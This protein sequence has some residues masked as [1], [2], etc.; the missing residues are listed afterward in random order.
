MW[1][2]DS[3]EAQRSG[4]GGKRRSNGA[5][6]LWPFWAEGSDTKP[7]PTTSRRKSCRSFGSRTGTPARSGGR[8][9]G[10]AAL[11]GSSASGAGAS[12]ARGCPPRTLPP[13]AA[14]LRA[15]ARTHC[16]VAKSALLGTPCGSGHF[17]RCS[18]APRFQTEPASLGFRLRENRKRKGGQNNERKPKTGRNPDDPRDPGGERRHHRQRNARRKEPHGLH[19]LGQ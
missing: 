1:S 8:R 13:P 19:P 12:I 3:A 17:S 2:R 18:L 6:D 16:L 15:E 11:R 5:S 4:F 14:D 7:A 9:H 10:R